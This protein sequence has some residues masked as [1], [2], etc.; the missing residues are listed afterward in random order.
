[1]AAEVDD[2]V[3][4][5]RQGPEGGDMGSIRAAEGGPGD[6]VTMANDR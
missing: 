2:M 3:E 5:S 6:E 4:W 1:M